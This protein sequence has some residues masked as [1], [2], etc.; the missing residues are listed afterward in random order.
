MW[1]SEYHR[2]QALTLS[3]LAQLTLNPNT[4]AALMRLAAQHAEM[5][6]RLEAE[7]HCDLPPP[8]LTT[9]KI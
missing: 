2:G 4:A 3:N 6:D 5:A 7:R 8:L 9:S 1:R